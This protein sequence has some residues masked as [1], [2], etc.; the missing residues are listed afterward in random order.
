MGFHVG[1]F[2]ERG[3]SVQAKVGFDGTVQESSGDN[4]SGVRATE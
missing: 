4:G 2:L 1:Q 3:N